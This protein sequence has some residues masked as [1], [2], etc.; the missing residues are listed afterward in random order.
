MSEWTQTNAGPWQEPRYERVV[1]P[2]RLRIECECVWHA[3][4]ISA[5][6]T[7]AG[8]SGIATDTDAAKAEAEDCLRVA[9]TEWLLDVGPELR[10]CDCDRRPDRQAG[11]PG[12][13]PATG[14]RWTFDEL[15]RCYCPEAVEGEVV[16]S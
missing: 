10:V 13:N 14:L 5:D 16:G 7:T 8:E 12:I 15:P 2:F 4:W 11:R 6:C 3:D 1:G 9:L